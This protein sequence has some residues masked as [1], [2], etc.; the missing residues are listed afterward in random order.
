MSKSSPFVLM[1]V[2][3]SQGEPSLADASKQLG[4]GVE[5]M[6]G[7]FGIV[8]VDPEKGIYAVQVRSDKLPA[9]Q[10]ESESSEYGGPWS[11]PRIAPFGPVKK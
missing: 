1:T 5:D 11:N 8:P 3:A 6:D 7:T 10:P 4:V 9:K 2:V